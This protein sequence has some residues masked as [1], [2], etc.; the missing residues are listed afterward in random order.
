M[1][2]RPA[3]L[4][5]SRSTTFPLF[6]ILPMVRPEND[7]NFVN[8]RLSMVSSGTWPSLEGS[9]SSTR[10]CMAEISKDF[11]QESKKYLP[12][13]QNCKTE[14][15]GGRDCYGVFVFELRSLNLY[16]KSRNLSV[17]LCLL[18]HC[19]FINR[20]G[21]YCI[22]RFPRL[23]CCDAFLPFGGKIKKLVGQFEF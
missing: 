4:P 9:Q 8:A 20:F 17:V 14:K 19:Y 22:H 11:H 3:Y 18:R 23:T 12:V 7:K 10:G 1:A 21:D 6:I 15:E 2:L 16:S 5:D 13:L